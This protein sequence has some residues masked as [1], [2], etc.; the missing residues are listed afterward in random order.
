MQLITED[1]VKPEN[2][3]RQFGIAQ[4]TNSWMMSDLVTNCEDLYNNFIV[5][6]FLFGLVQKF[7]EPTNDQG[8]SA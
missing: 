2:S 1:S 7:G 3:I 5:K 8:S 6:K 4:A